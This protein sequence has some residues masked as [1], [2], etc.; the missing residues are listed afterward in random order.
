MTA[1]GCMV[2]VVPLFNSIGGDTFS[3]GMPAAN[4][5]L[6]DALSCAIAGP[7]SEETDNDITAEATIKGFTGSFLTVF[8]TR[9]T[10]PPLSGSLN[11]P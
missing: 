1:L 6:P 8:N 9:L 3:A 2:S 7:T 10:G 5:G 11:V 4:G